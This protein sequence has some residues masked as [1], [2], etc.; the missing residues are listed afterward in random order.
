ML[1]YA[2]AVA[3]WMAGALACFAGGTGLVLRVLPRLGPAD[4]R[5]A[6]F[7]VAAFEPLLVETVVGGQFAGWAYVAFAAA[8][9]ADRQGRPWTAGLALG[10]LLYKPPLLALA[11]IGLVAGRRWRTVAGVAA[12]AAAAAGVSLAVVG[13]EGIVAWVDGMLRFA[14]RTA[15]GEAFLADWKYVDVRSFA[16]LLLPGHPGAGRALATAG[17]AAAIGVLGFAWWRHGGDDARRPLLWAATLAWTPVVGGYG[18][19]YDTVLVALALL[20]VADAAVADAHRR[21]AFL[22]MLAAVAVVPWVTQ[23]LAIATGVQVYTVVL[24]AVGA[25]CFRLARA[26]AGWTS[27]APGV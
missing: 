3:V 8:L 18:P 12:G 16:R 6:F 9:V 27:A 22:R 24:L 7:L 21:R 2:V 14:A 26:E 10:A 15:S 25:W 17:A 1:P 5:T 19:V 11:G 13:V 4:R 20:V 23:P